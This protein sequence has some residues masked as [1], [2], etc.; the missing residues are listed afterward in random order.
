MIPDTAPRADFGLI[1][2]KNSGP[3]ARAEGLKNLYP[4]FGSICDSQAPGP[5]PVC[6]LGSTVLAAVL[7]LDPGPESDSAGLG[8]GPDI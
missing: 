2:K 6:W 7:L 1:L 3:S 4:G 8:Q 5:L